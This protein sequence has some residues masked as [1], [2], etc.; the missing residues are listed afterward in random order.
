MAPQ[1]PV[2][3]EPR[4]A[5]RRND[6]KLPSGRLQDSHE[7]YQENTDLRGPTEFSIF[8]FANLLMRVREGARGSR[9]LSPLSLCLCR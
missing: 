2:P 8:I 3:L 6:H 5:P 7:L 1:A 4:D 9:R